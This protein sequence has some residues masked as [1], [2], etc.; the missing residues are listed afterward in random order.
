[1]TT[2]TI[3]IERSGLVH[4]ADN[5]SQRIDAYIPSERPQNHAANLLHLPNGDVLC[6]WFGAPRKGCRTY[7]FICRGW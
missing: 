4:P 5:D 2:E 1:M 3:T 7:R 6:V